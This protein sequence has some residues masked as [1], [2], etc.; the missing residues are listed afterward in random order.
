MPAILALRIQ[1]QDDR[2]F[3]IIL[4]YVV[5]PRPAKATRDLVS[6]YSGRLKTNN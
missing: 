6:K 5:T 3:K 4:G 1:R 2:E